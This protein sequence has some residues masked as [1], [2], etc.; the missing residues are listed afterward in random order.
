MESVFREILKSVVKPLW[1]SGRFGKSGYHKSSVKHPL[2]FSIRWSTCFCIK[3]C[4]EAAPVFSLSENL[5]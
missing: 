1:Q 5:A 4:R 2:G 3:G